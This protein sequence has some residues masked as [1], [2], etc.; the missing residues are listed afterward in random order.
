MPTRR[1]Y[2]HKSRLVRSNHLRLPARESFPFCSC[3][4]YRR[5]NSTHPLRIQAANMALTT[6]ATTATPPS[7]SASS[8]STRRMTATA[9]STGS[10]RDGRHRR[11]PTSQ[12][13]AGGG[14]HHGNGASHT[15]TASGEAAR[16][17]PASRRPERQHQAREGGGGDGGGG[18]GI[19]ATDLAEDDVGAMVAGITS[20][21]ALAGDGQTSGGKTEESR[22]TSAVAVAAPPAPAAAAAAA[23]EDAAAAGV[24]IR[25][26]ISGAHASFLHMRVFPSTTAG[27]VRGG[28]KAAEARLIFDENA[29]LVEYIAPLYG[30]RVE[31]LR[32]SAPMEEWEPTVTAL[33]LVWRATLLGIYVKSLDSVF[34]KQS[35]PFDAI[36]L[37][38]LWFT[39]AGGDGVGSVA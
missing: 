4:S 17:A 16:T 22:S 25:V 2:I 32:L 9:T 35:G 36:D 6:T 24:V 31:T 11:Y 8:S 33:G 34:S 10:G 37:Q 27:Q 23:E 19:S 26:L 5:V 12:L 3:F 1:C 30:A 28:P 7:S 18:G 13:N 39:V 21:S 38:C 14:G 15:R 29:H 20:L